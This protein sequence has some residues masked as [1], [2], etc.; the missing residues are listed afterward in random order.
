VCEECYLSDM[1]PRSDSISSA[2]DLQRK[3]VRAI[4]WLATLPEGL[5]QAK[6]QADPVVIALGSGDGRL[7]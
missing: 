1:T 3:P 5:A 6:P 4:A 7:A 2:A